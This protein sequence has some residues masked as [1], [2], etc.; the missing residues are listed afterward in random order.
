VFNGILPGVII[1]I[2]L[3][4][5]YRKRMRVLETSRDRRQKELH[6]AQQGYK[7][8]GI[9]LVGLN[10]MLN[11]PMHGLDVSPSQKDYDAALANMQQQQQP[12]CHHP[13]VEQ[14]Q[15]HQDHPTVLYLSTHKDKHYLVNKCQELLNVGN[16]G[17][18]KDK[19]AT[20]IVIEMLRL[21][22]SSS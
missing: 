13:T 14:L 22:S 5:K 3:L 17:W 18:S 10:K 19:L 11:N 16:H 7:E 1:E 8:Q 9:E 12:D 15:Q 21:R 2:G 6:T 4:C 20:K